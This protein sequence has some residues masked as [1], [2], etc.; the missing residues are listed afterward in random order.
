VDPIALPGVG[1]EPTY[2]WGGLLTGPDDDLPVGVLGL[3]DSS[4]PARWRAPRPT[5]AGPSLDVQHT[6]PSLDTHDAQGPAAPAT[7]AGGPPISAARA[8]LLSIHR[9][10]RPSRPVPDQAADHDEL[11]GTIGPAGVAATPAGTVPTGSGPHTG[12]A[13]EGSS[14]CS[15]P[16]STPGSDSVEAHVRVSAGSRR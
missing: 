15:T 1:V 10:A 14:T 9:R 11:V 4:R 12:A 3:P 8:S 7:T 2:R 5:L 13:A 6:P 16:S